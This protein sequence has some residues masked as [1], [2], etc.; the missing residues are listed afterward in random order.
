MVTSELI[1]PKIIYEVVK[2]VFEDFDEF[3]NLHP[4]FAVLRKKEM[5]EEALSAPLHVGAL[6]YYKERGW[7]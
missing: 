2:S 1:S 4:A 5:I 6:R 7:I 3:R